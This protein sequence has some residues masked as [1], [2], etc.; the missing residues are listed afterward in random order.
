LK[1][2]PTTTTTQFVE[3]EREKHTH[4]NYK[5][6]KQTFPFPLCSFISNLVMT[7]KTKKTIVHITGGKETAVKMSFSL[8]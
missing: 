8:F 7:A 3:S 2:K 4:G 5:I 1:R 6:R